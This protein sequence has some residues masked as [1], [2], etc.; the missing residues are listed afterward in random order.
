MRSIAVRRAALAASAATFALLVT[1]CGGSSDDGDKAGDGKGAQ[2]GATATATASAAPAKALTSADLEK[3]ALTQQD[4]KSGTVVT[5]VPAKD[6][7]AQDK[8]TADDA[9]CTPLALL[10]TGSYV[11]KPAATAKRAWSD[12][13]KKPAAGASDADAMLAAV[14]VAKVQLTLASYENGGAE[15]VMKDLTAAA[16]KCAGGFTYTAAGEKTKILK[17]TTTQAPEGAD[18]ALAVTLLVDAEDDVKMPVKAVAAR[19]GATLV[20]IPAVNFAS[21]ATGEDFSFPTQILQAQLAK[22]G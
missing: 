7:I 9:A 20:L 13:P 8:V 11:G 6:D 10:Q 12:T 16:G 14:D 18:E 19:K 5:K 15:Q 2:A 22:L 4:V 3:A 17:V 21:A 1:A